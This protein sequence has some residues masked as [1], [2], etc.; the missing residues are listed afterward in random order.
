MRS[1]FSDFS[2]MSG[3]VII[4]LSIMREEIRDELFI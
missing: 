3:I 4:F 1:R 2:T